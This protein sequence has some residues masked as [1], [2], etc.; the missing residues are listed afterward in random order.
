MNITD[1][2]LLGVPLL[3]MAILVLLITYI[4]DE[5]ER[6]S[7]FRLISESF[8]SNFDGIGDALWVDGFR[9]IGG[10]YDQLNQI[11][12]GIDNVRDS[13]AYNP[14]LS[15]ALEKL[16]DSVCAVQV[17]VSLLRQNAEGR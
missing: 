8:S 2:L 12:Q 17:E 5:K 7:R 3:L 6:H 9:N 11:R 15:N 1:F 16:N 10:L 4:S 14:E 13:L